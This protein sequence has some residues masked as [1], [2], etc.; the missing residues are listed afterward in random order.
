MFIIMNFLF[1]KVRS[2]LHCDL[3]DDFQGLGTFTKQALHCRNLLYLLVV[4][5][6]FKLSPLY[7]SSIEN[8]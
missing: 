4:I 5:E 2:L 8:D 1:G 3:A 7:I 6:I